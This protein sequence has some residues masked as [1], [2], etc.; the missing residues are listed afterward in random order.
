MTETTV[1]DFDAPI[2]TDP[3]SFYEGNK[4]KFLADKTGN[5]LDARFVNFNY[6]GKSRPSAHLRLTVEIDGMEKQSVEHMKT[7]GGFEEEAPFK[8][9]KDGAYLVQNP[10][11]TPKGKK[12]IRPKNLN[13]ST[14]TGKFL[15][16]LR[17][18]LGDAYAER[19]ADIRKLAGM[20][21]TVGEVVEPYDF[22]DKKTGEKKKGDSHAVIV[23]E[24]HG[25]VAVTAAA[26][27]SKANGAL[28]A[29]VSEIITG[30][31]KAQT[32]VSKAQLSGLVFASPK[33]TS[34]ADK[35]AASQLVNDAAFLGSLEGLKF[36]GTTLTI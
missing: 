25:E 5:I 16:S 6:N 13:A 30:I 21:V 14:P 28:K 27:A 34:I 8:P 32:K 18:L 15:K 33:L 36:D 7:G 29:E 31:V 20:R 17:P 24:Y 35:Q 1:D 19:T 11:Y 23:T 4:K 9:G 2:G 22:K 10:D 12:G 3:D 26:P